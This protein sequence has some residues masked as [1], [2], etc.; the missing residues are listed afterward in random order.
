ML[1][2]W[3]S[4]DVSQQ[5]RCIMPSSRRTRPGNPRPAQREPPTSRPGTRQRIQRKASKPAYPRLRTS[6]P[7]P[8]A[9]DHSREWPERWDGLG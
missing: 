9:S 3:A 7:Q 8:P 4:L 6:K 5:R 2:P 1:T